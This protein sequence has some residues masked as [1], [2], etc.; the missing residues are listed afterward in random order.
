[1]VGKAT[2]LRQKMGLVYCLTYLQDY[3]IAMDSKMK[4]FWFFLLLLITVHAVTGQAPG[5]EDLGA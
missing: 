4:I 2:S 3:L 1:M 5:D